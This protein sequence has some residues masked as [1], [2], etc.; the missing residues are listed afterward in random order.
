MAADHEQEE[1][2]VLHDQ[3]RL[4]MDIHRTLQQMAGIRGSVRASGVGGVGG[5]GGAG[6]AIQA[7][8][9]VAALR[10]LTDVVRQT[11]AVV[12]QFADQRL[13]GGGT[14]SQT[15]QASA[16]LGGIGVNDPAAMAA[17]LRE[18][19]SGGGLARQAASQLGVGNVLPRGFGSTNDVQILV[20]LAEGL[21]R[22]NDLERARLLSIQLQEPELLRLTQM[23]EAQFQTSKKLAEQQAQVFTPEAQRR[24]EQFAI[25]MNQLSQKFDLA[26]GRVGDFLLRLFGGAVGVDVNGPQRGGAKDAISR[27][28]Q[29]V[30]QNTIALQ[31]MGRQMFGG[32]A[33]ARGALPAGLRGEVLRHAMEGEALKLGAF[34][35]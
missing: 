4:L 31:S 8:A 2:A 34:R 18:R 33:R 27:N 19:I 1:V 3:S 21:R 12:K 26:K 13:F 15:A 6:L 30:E 32:G 11:T 23:S 29:A 10:L 24:A 17:R 16:L 9:A 35:L 25:T 14:T 5:G 20:Q 28:T 22:T 7:V